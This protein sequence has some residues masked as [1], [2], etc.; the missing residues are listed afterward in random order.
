MNSIANF[1]ATYKSLKTKSS[2]KA[3]IISIKKMDVQHP[4]EGKHMNFI[5]KNDVSIA[6]DSHAGAFVASKV[7]KRKFQRLNYL[8]LLL[9]ITIFSIILVPTSVIA[10]AIEVPGRGPGDGKDRVH[11]EKRGFRPEVGFQMNLL[12]LLSRFC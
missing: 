6:S 4:E 10:V 3:V 2:H 11:D 1:L 5:K 7:I 8:F 12:L 9:P